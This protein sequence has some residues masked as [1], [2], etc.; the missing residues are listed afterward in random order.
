MQ[1]QGG[2]MKKPGIALAIAPRRSFQTTNKCV[3]CLKHAEAQARLQ[4][5]AFWVQTGTD[6]F[7][8]RDRAA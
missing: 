4:H 5:E 3:R 8:P 1:L 6:V 7:E 2:L